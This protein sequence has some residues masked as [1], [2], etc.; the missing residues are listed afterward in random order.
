MDPNHRI[1][2][3]KLRNR[4]TRFRTGGPRETSLDLTAQISSLQPNSGHAEGACDLSTRC[5]CSDGKPG[6]RNLGTDGTF[7]GNAGTD[8]AFPF[9][10][11]EGAWDDCGKR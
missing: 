9:V 3:E 6:D 2:A 4:A 1:R 7:P 8:E 5:T 11:A 10:E